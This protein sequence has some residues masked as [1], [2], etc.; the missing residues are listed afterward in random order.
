MHMTIYALT[1]LNI[2]QNIYI[3]ISIQVQIYVHICSQGRRE[4]HGS[5]ASLTFF[6]IS[7]T[8]VFWLFGCFGVGSLLR[9]FVVFRVQN[10][11][12]GLHKITKKKKKEK[13]NEAIY[14]RNMNIFWPHP[15]K[16]SMF[17]REYLIFP[18]ETH[19]AQ[20]LMKRFVVTP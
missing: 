16:E 14:S 10:R 4:L 2:Y 13:N 19:L 3:H 20:N 5:L 15:T 12:E 11:L 7:C 17:F 6:P 8:R 18:E 1:Y 9:L